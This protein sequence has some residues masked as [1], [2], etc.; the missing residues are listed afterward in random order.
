MPFASTFDHVGIAVADLDRAVRWYGEALELVVEFEFALEPFGL[1][2]VVLKSASGY[3]IELLERAGSA[4]GPRP[5]GPLDA[6]LT[7][8][9]GHMCLDVA[10]VD[11]AF[12][13]LLTAGAAE[14]MPPRPS[15]EPGVRMAYVADPEGNLIELIDRAA[16]SSA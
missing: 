3:R 6:C 7:Q 2:G 9:F 10:D 11:Q 5:A 8:G 4:P 15:P 12:G 16:R 13:H 1:R 14:R